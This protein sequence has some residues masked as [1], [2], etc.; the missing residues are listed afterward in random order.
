[1]KNNLITFII[2]A[3]VLGFLIIMLLARLMAPC[4]LYSLSRASDVPARCY[5]GFKN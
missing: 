4:S 3:A 2:I 1:M 5:Q